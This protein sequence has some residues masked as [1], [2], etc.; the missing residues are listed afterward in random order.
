MEKSSNYEIESLREV[1]AKLSKVGK[2]RGQQNPSQL[3]KTA[4]LSRCSFRDGRNGPR[5][6]VARLA[7]RFYAGKDHWEK[8]AV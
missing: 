3:Q 1:K 6:H 2:E 5:K 4:V 8:L 7:K